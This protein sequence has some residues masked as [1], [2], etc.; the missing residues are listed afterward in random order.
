MKSTRWTWRRLDELGF[1]GRGKSR[2]RPRNEPSLYG[3]PYPFI[4]TA[5]IMAADPYV[6]TYSQTYSELGFRQ[7]K[8]WPTNTLCMTIA[9]ANTAKVAILKIEACFPDSVVG[10]IPDKSKADLHFVLYSLGLMKDQ[11]L[12]VSRGATQ[13]NLGLGK[14]LSFPLLVPDV[15]QQRRIAAVLSAYDELIENNKQRIALLEKLAEQI[16]R[17]WF[18]RLRFPGHEKVKLENR[19]L[20]E[21]IS[22]YVGG[23]WGE[24]IQSPKFGNRVY[25]IR[26]TD[27]ESVQQGDIFSVP[28]RFIKDSALRNR[29][30][31]AGDLI[32]EN[33]VNHQSRTSGKSLLVTQHVLDLFDGDVICASFCKLIRPK[34]IKHSKFLALNFRLLF[35]QGL[36]DYFQNIATN[37][38]ANLQAERFMDRHL[39]PFDDSIDLSIF[40]SLDTSLLARAQ[41]K[42]K[43]TRDKLLPRLISGKLSVENLDIQ[44]PPGM[45]EESAFAEA[46]VGQ[47]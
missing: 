33:S 46:T 2:H 40:E 39:I 36:F 29:K 47:G 11:F 34:D 26:G 41:A 9:G 6:T 23:D 4:Q 18:V 10:F 3:G 14:L 7:S 27:F 16:Y 19:P 5:D 31:K 20:R 44:F 35:D 15:R 12:S 21:F 45:A 25:V 37:G 8:M 22:E 43:E 28:L 17:E 1:V 30:L 24:D 42:L 38:I 32:A 13:D